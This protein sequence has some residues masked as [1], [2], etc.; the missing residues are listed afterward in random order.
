M[1]RY[2]ALLTAAAAL[3]AAGSWRDKDPAQW[4]PEEVR[5]I[6]GDS[7][8]AKVVAADFEPDQ[9]RSGMP[10]EGRGGGGRGNWGGGGGAGGG[11][12]GGGA[13]PTPGSG[14]NWG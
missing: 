14:G 3:A 4:T 6:L 10:A 11:G 9:M 2:L 13:M 12:G 7:P 1:V 5:R 8:W